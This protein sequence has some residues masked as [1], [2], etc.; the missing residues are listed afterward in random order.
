MAPKS[1]TVRR[2]RKGRGSE[3][4]ALR[5]AWHVTGAGVD[6]EDRES[7]LARLP[8]LSR[9]VRDFPVAELHVEVDRNPRKGGFGVSVSLPLP[10][11]TLHAAEWARDPATA[12]RRAMDKVASQVAAYRALLRRYER[13]SHRRSPSF[14]PV[15]P[16]DRIPPRERRALEALR[17]RLARHVR[18]EI[19]HDPSLADLPKEAI[20]VPDVVDEAFVWTL[21]NLSRRPAVLSPEQFLWRRMLHQFDLARESVLRRAAAEKEEA[22]AESRHV[23]PEPEVDMEWEEAQDLLFG[24]GEPLPLDLDEASRAGSDPAE[25]LGREELGRAVGEALRELPESHRRAILL[26]DLEGYDPQEIAFILSVGEER[27]RADLDSA[28]RTL[29]RRLREFA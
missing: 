26:H 11:R 8:Q 5:V 17:P 29:R 10:R 4:P 20:S 9:A 23:E 18:H 19:V 13:R 22:R 27:V 14:A 2:A 24:G 15:P 21:E 1:G 3:V 25:I 16:S 12:G 7:V 6:A 28:R